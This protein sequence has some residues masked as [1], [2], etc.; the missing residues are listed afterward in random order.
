[1]ILYLLDKTVKMLMSITQ[2]IAHNEHARKTI[3]TAHGFSKLA[4]NSCDKGPAKTRQTNTFL[5]SKLRSN[6][7]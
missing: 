7:Y 1:V 5:L 4:W 2:K 3:N 6:R